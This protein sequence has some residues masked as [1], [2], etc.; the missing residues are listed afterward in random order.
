VR[1]LIWKK[2]IESRMVKL[3]EMDKKLGMETVP[4]IVE[5]R[6]DGVLMIPLRLTFPWVRESAPKFNVELEIKKLDPAKVENN[7]MVVVPTTVKEA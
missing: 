4:S 7:P 2:R 1:E 3:P 6:R 5:I